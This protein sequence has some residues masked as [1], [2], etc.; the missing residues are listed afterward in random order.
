MEEEAEPLLPLVASWGEVTGGDSYTS[1]RVRE[2]IQKKTIESLTA[3]K[4][5]GVSGLVVKPP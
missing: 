5:G 2:G 4:P 3:V 1:S